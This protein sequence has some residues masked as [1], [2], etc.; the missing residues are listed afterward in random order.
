MTTYVY[1]CLHMTRHIQGRVY[2]GYTWVQPYIARY[3]QVISYDQDIPTY[4]HIYLGI[5]RVYPGYILDICGYTLVICVIGYT[6]LY[7]G[8]PR[9][10]PHIARYTLGI[11]NQ[12][13]PWVYPYMTRVYPGI[14]TYGQVYPGYTQVQKWIYPGYIHVQLGIPWIYLGIPSYLPLS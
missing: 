11:S 13:Y 5:P 2:P 9:V 8:I 14:P 1:I 12:V 6:Q 3:T 10:Y 7:V 4:T